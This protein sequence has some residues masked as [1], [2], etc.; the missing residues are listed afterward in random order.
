MTL[1]NAVIDFWLWIRYGR[2]V[3]TRKI[4]LEVY[5]HNG[6]PLALV[7]PEGAEVLYDPGTKFFYYAVCTRTGD[8]ILC[9]S[10]RE[11][12]GVVAIHND[13]RGQGYEDTR[14]P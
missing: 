8:E 10:K 12:D 4:V 1:R 14:L 2:W 13:S 5:N 9:D 7:K 11:A 3:V 6:F